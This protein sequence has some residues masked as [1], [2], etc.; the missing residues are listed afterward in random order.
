VIGSPDTGKYSGDA[1]KHPIDIQ[2]LPDVGVTFPGALTSGILDAAGLLSNEGW[3]EVYSAHL[4]RTEPA[5]M[6]LQSGCSYYFVLTGL[7]DAAFVSYRSHVHR[8]KVLSVTFL[9]ISRSAVANATI[10]RGCKKRCSLTF[11]FIS[12]RLTLEPQKPS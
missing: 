3:L 4:K 8:G 7:N 6:M 2:V 5:V 9:T 12:I 10:W 11:K 1:R